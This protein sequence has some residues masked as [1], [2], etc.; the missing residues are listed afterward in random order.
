LKN[1]D[2]RFRGTGWPGANDRNNKRRRV[3]N[4]TKAI[5]GGPV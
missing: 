1:M 3:N 5:D 4:F 2:S